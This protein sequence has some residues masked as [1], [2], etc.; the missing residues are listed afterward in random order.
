MPLY[1]AMIDHLHPNLWPAVV[2]EL[3]VMIA[4]IALIIWRVRHKDFV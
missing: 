2:V 3:L 4:V 1:Y